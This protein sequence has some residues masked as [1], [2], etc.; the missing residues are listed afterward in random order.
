MVQIPYLPEKLQRLSKQPSELVKEEDPWL[1][2]VESMHTRGFGNLF[3]KHQT[4]VVM[5]DQKKIKFLRAYATTGRKGFAAQSVGVSSALVATHAKEDPVFAAAIT[6]AE[7]YFQD[8]LVGEMFRRGV[9]GF[10]KEVIGGKNK[11]QII[12]IIEYSDKALELVSRVHIP[13]MQRKQIEVKTETKTEAT[14]NLVTTNNID[15]E[16]MSSTD[17]AMFKQL[18][19]NQAKVQEDLAADDD[20]IEA[21]FSDA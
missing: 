3:C 18:L 6:E 15:I 10:K 21:E 14:L 20:A 7:Q 5:N 11:N 8:L 4:G 2:I 1:V 19:L 12:E 16:N 17:R 13:A 9:T